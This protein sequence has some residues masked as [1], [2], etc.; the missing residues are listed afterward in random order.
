MGGAVEKEGAAARGGLQL[1]R[2]ASTD[3]VMLP[4]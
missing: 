3:A 1:H 4:A 2:P